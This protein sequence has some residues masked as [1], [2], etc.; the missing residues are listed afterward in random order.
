MKM[1]VDDYLKLDYDV[2]VIPEECTDGT[3]C[4]RAEHPQLSGCMSH[5]S[6]PEDALRNLIE[7]KRLYIETLY[8]K[9]LEVPLPVRT[10]GGTFSSYKSITTILV[11]LEEK[12]NL[13][14]NLPSEFDMPH[15]VSDTS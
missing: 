6:T 15:S 4:Y 3:L 11:P 10:T 8:E 2:V 7:A 1:T 5:G 12:E 9:G 13:Q 14:I